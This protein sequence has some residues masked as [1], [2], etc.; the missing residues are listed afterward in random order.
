MKTNNN[1]VKGNR[2]KIKTYGSQR[3]GIFDTLESKLIVD[4]EGYLIL[5]KSKKEAKEYMDFLGV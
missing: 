2:F 5:F 3:F 4:E 1:N